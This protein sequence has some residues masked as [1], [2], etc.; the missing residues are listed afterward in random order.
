MSNETEIL[1]N[2]MRED[3]FEVVMRGYNRRQVDDY[4][5]RSRNQIRDLE[6]RL[7]RALDEV[8]GV[9]RE[10]AEI[11]NQSAPA[12]PQHE[13][14]SERLAQILALAEEEAAQKRTAADEEIG[15]SRGE[16]EE[17]AKRLVQE[18]TD[19]A[20]NIRSSAQAQAEQTVSAA[21]TEAD[22][23]IS[24]S[25]EQAERAVE[26]ARS[27]AES[28]LGDAERRAATINDGA[29]RRLESLTATHTEAVRRLNEVHDVLGNLLR[30]DET[31]GPF[32]EIGGPVTATSVA[33]HEAREM[34]PE[35]QM[36]PSV[37]DTADEEPPVEADTDDDPM[38]VDDA[39]D[40]TDDINETRQIPIVT[41]ATTQDAEDDRSEIKPADDE[42]FEESVRIIHN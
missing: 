8:E 4:V 38:A 34:A 29:S 9:R 42:G 26:E 24:G 36:A 11:R 27:R 32:D 25:K 7:A 39:D 14:V 19:E 13:E 22:H 10:V 30:S 31:A 21:N 12:K 17:E 5:T 35:P 33:D 40:T 3:P 23:L 18:A 15:R 6:E 41:D 1:P 28:L 2:L 16:A 37:D 20:D